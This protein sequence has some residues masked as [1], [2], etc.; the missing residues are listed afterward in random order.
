MKKSKAFSY[1]VTKKIH[2]FDAEKCELY[3]LILETWING[4][5]NEASK[6]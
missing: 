5:Y 4:N 6:T 1:F 2:M 3:Y